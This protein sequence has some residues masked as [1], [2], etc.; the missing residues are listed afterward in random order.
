MMAAYTAFACA[1]IHLEYVAFFIERP[2]IM[3]LVFL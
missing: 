1:K 3:Y 2:V